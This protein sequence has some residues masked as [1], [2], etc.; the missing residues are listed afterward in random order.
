MLIRFDLLSFICS[1]SLGF[2]YMSLLSLVFC[3]KAH[4]WS[5]V[6][7][8]LLVSSYLFPQIMF[9]KFVC[10]WVTS[11]VFTCKLFIASLVHFANKKLESNDS[12]DDN[13]ENDQ[14]CNVQQ[15]HHG[16]DDRVENHLQAYV[17]SVSLFSVFKNPNTYLIWVNKYIFYTSKCQEIC[18]CQ[19]LCP[20]QRKS[21]SHV[22]LT[23]WLTNLLLTWI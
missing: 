18:V 14:K 9:I 3:L 23:D 13:N 5:C 4:Y 19:G 11:F 2:T 8:C 1:P 15:W 6:V 22:R 7:L 20:F 12:V 16:F 17:K 10:T 21:L